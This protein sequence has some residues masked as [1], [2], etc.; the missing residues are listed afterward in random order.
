MVRVIAI[1]GPSAVGKSTVARELA[2]LI[3]A[4]VRHCG[5]MI[6]ARAS[7]LGVSPDM[8]SKEDHHVIDEETRR[9]ARSSQGPLI[10]EGRFLRYVLT[11]VPKV[12]FVELTCA[13]EERRRRHSFR[14]SA[15]RA[16]LLE[17]QDAA[18]A[19]LQSRLF[20]NEPRPDEGAIAVCTDGQRP[21]EV[22]MRILEQ[23]ERLTPETNW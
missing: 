8:L 12:V 7:S 20:E 17:D 18:G 15:P 5:D 1:F 4:D 16:G 13:E 3:H 23:I 9:I 10:A 14:E 6:R 21:R 2:E 19:V 11:G 22:A